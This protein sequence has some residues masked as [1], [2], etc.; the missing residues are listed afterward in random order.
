MLA[1]V[2]VS[3]IYA[4][5]SSTTV[6]EKAKI[7]PN[8]VTESYFTIN[9]EKTIQSVEI[10]NILGQQ[11]Q[12]NDNFLDTKVRIDL[13]ISENGIYLVKIIYK[14]KTEYVQRIYVK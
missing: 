8:P 13:N 5:N 2:L 4:G 14:D 9:A 3:I 6:T 1:L 10:L 11:V 7:Y 12:K